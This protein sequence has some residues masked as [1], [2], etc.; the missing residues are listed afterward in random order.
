MPHITPLCCAGRGWL[1][2]GASNSGGAVLRQHFSDADL[3]RLT[4]QV[5]PENPT[6]LDY[7]P[8]PAVGERFPV[9]DDGKRPVLEPRPDADAVFMQ[10]AHHASLCSPQVLL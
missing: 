9:R 3:R 6:G 8:L 5:D 4:P 2:G 1:V 10:G 7:Y